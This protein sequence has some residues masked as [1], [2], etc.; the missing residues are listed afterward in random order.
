MLF[1]S[2][3]LSLSVINWR[4]RLHNEGCS[5]CILKYPG[6]FVGSISGPF[7]ELYKH[8]LFWLYDAIAKTWL[9]KNCPLVKKPWTKH[10]IFMKR[11]LVLWVL[12]I[13]CLTCTFFI[14]GDL[15]GRDAIILPFHCLVK[16]GLRDEQSF[17]FLNLTP[18]LTHTSRGIKEHSQF[19]WISGGPLVSS[20]VKTEGSWFISAGL[21]FLVRKWNYQI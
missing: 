2:L 8:L 15:K 9:E 13:C 11:L 10:L 3:S 14:L 20:R 4:Y 5:F 21:T 19:S 7:L 17:G 16:K 18:T 1:Y 6:V 12:V